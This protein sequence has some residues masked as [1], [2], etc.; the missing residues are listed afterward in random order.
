MKKILI[1]Q[2]RSRPEMSTAEQGEYQRVVGSMADVSFLSALD[3]SLAWDEPIKI[4][5][6]FDAMFLAGS[7]EFDLHSDAEPETRMVPAQ[8]ILLRLTPFIKFILEQDFPT[9]GICFGH[10]LIGEAQCGGV[11]TDPK[12]EKVGSFSVLL[13]TEGKQDRLFRD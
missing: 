9:F 13:T 6:G 7:G 4:L 1:I 2:S 11:I 5:E 10:Q 3:E 12:Q 8:T